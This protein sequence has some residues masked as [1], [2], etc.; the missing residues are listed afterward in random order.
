MLNK[1]ICLSV[2]SLWSPSFNLYCSVGEV[3]SLHKSEIGFLCFCEA[4]K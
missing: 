1:I 4:T 3:S 2:C